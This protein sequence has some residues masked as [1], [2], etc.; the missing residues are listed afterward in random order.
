MFF[1]ELCEHNFI[2]VVF[3]IC[4][5]QFMTSSFSIEHKLFFKVYIY[6]QMV[7]HAFEL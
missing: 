4:I 6:F 3:G 7:A 1:I 2:Q 5:I